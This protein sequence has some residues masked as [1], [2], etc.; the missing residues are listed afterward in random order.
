MALPAFRPAFLRSFRCAG[1]IAEALRSQ[2]LG[3]VLALPSA[4]PRAEREETVDALVHLMDLPVRAVGSLE[5]E[6]RA[7]P[8]GEI[9]VLAS[10]VEVEPAPVPG[11]VVVCAIRSA[12]PYLDLPQEMILLRDAVIQCWGLQHDGTR[13]REVAVWLSM[14][15]DSPTTALR[16]IDGALRRHLA[17]PDA[18]DSALYLA[19]LAAAVGWLVRGADGRGVEWV[20]ARAVD[21]PDRGRLVG[22]AAAVLGEE[23]A[24]RLAFNAGLVMT[25]PQE[26]GDLLDLRRPLAMLGMRE[27]MPGTP[28]LPDLVE[29]L[30]REIVPAAL[31]VLQRSLH[32]APS[33]LGLEGP[34]PP[35]VLVGRD[36]ELRR[37]ITLCEPANE[38]RT[39]VLHG[40]PGSGKSA[41]AARLGELLRARLTP[42]WVRFDS[43]AEVGWLPV[44]RALDVPTG[45]ARDA[46]ER[47][48]LD[49]TGVGEGIAAP[50]DE[51]GVPLWVREVHRRLQAGRYLIV[52][53]GV[54][55]MAEEDLPE[56][57][58]TGPG[59][60]SVLVLSETAQRP[61]QRSHEAIAMRLPPLSDSEARRLLASKAPQ[62]AEAILQGGADALIKHCGGVAA[63]LVV[64]GELLQRGSI[65]EV[66]AQVAAGD[67]SLSEVLGRALG[68]L[69][70]SEFAVLRALAVGAPK[71]SPVVLPIA[72]A[73]RSD[74]GD[75]LERVLDRGLAVRVGRLVYP[76]LDVGLDPQRLAQDKEEQLLWGPILRRHA[77]QVLLLFGNAVT[78]HDRSLQE[79]LQDDLLHALNRLDPRDGHELNLLIGL[80]DMFVQHSPSGH[81]EA[82]GQVLDAYHRALGRIQR[83]TTPERWAAVRINMAGTR[84]QQAAS[85]GDVALREAARWL[86]EAAE[87][88]PRE[89][90]PELWA[91]AQ[92]NLGMTL[93]QLHTTLQRSDA[94][95]AEEILKKAIVAFRSASAVRAQG[96]HDV[97]WAS[98]M[99]RLANALSRQSEVSGDD[100]EEM[101]DAHRA[102]LSVLTRDAMPNEW[103]AM[104]INLSSAL[105]RV[106]ARQG[107]PGTR[108]RMLKEAVEA[109]EA[110]LSVLH[111]EQQP[112]LWGAANHNL[113]TVL[114]HLPGTPA[115]ENAR[116]AIDAFQAALAVFTPAQ[117]PMQWATTK[118]SL[119]TALRCLPTGDRAE[120]L[121]SAIDAYR[122][123]LS[124]LTEKD[125]PEGQEAV[126]RAL[127]DALQELAA[128]GAEESGAA[129]PDAAG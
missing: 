83:E 107:D 29:A 14:A 115:E 85:E 41:L 69:D 11:A 88:A 20:L 92:E 80:C 74:A 97:L 62:H 113:G 64:I 67:P 38:V 117:S 65:Q 73:G 7:E 59:R 68:R 47:R 55:G 53:D 118:M 27:E 24:L 35:R 93:L 22:T 45:E 72:I 12:P 112:T 104:Q 103:A 32:A 95:G 4:L 99:A 33:G 109:C 30:R 111:P 42:V 44:A 21:A 122:E 114:A 23:A 90:H 17:D 121:R 94:E 9:L 3:Q 60:C 66:E 40:V 34:K 56:W 19:G 81:P 36:E 71:G 77:E 110:A 125:F 96:Q 127:E 63:I 70:E 101:L 123:S 89:R 128:L 100:I 18:S 86:E 78:T 46:Q 129:S 31:A 87:A 58:P 105:D 126:Q 28:A 98:T 8:P 61:L 52:V 119:G 75:A 48:L 54:D 82:F 25:L 26:P 5:R 84:V 76:V 91:A 1:R 13:L 102:T 106:A 16:F 49:I 116:R 51:A 108:A 50:R 57:L 120:N 10:P 43:G 39:T 15:T 124:V 2:L 79:D 37:L 6:A